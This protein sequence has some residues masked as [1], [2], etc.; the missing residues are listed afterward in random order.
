MCGMFAGWA[1]IG[2][3]L[4][5]EDCARCF[6]PARSL[7]SVSAAQTEEQHVWCGTIRL[8]WCRGAASR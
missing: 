7:V 6:Y 1:C 3:R 8:L 4:F 2:L 5:S